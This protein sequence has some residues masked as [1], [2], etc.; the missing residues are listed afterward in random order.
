MSSCCLVHRQDSQQHTT[1]DPPCIAGVGKVGFADGVVEQFDGPCGREPLV[2][3]GLDHRA[4]V[5]WWDC[6][7]SAS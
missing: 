2:P 6:G 3:V 1:E 4:C 5:R 7:D